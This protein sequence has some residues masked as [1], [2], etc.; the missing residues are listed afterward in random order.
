MS[1]QEKDRLEQEFWRTGTAKTKMQ[2]MKKR[3]LEQALDS[4]NH[5]IHMVKQKLR[6][7]NALIQK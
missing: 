3:E 1:I 4:S 6:D 7:M 2:I 5:R